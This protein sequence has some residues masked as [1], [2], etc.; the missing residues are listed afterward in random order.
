LVRQSDNSLTLPF[1]LIEMVVLGAI[2]TL[3]HAKSA[4]KVTALFCVYGVFY[5]LVLGG[6]V[7]IPLLELTVLGPWVALGYAYVSILPLTILL[8][9]RVTLRAPAA[10]GAPTAAPAAEIEVAPILASP[11]PEGQS[12]GHHVLSVLVILAPVGC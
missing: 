8:E 3:L 10:V 5:E 4:R 1:L 12:L 11:T 7:G 2:A 6:L 9:D